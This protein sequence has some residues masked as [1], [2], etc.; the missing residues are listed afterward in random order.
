MSEEFKVRDGKIVMENR[1]FRRIAR[2]AAALIIASYT[3]F[4]VV[5]KWTIGKVDLDAVDYTIL[6][7]SLLL[8]IAVEIA[9]AIAKRKTGK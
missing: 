5:K 4:V 1:L 9:V 7:V 8:L 2:W 6:S 3:I